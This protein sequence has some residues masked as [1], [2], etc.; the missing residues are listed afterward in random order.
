MSWTFLQKYP[1][2]LFVRQVAEALDTNPSAIYRWIREKRLTAI[3]IGRFYRIPKSKLIEFLNLE[4]EA[5]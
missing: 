1:D 2:L 4:V 3:R 5:H